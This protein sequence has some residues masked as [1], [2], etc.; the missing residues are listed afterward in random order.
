MREPEQLLPDGLD[1]SGILTY[2][3]RKQVMTQKFENSTA[4]RPDG[5]GIA[6]SHQAVCRKDINQDGLL[7]DER[8]DCVLAWT[9]WHKIIEGHLY[10]RYFHSGLILYG[11]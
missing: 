5:I 10:P 8:L 9:L 6:R 11:S 7:L 2:E 4:P 1:L 3:Q